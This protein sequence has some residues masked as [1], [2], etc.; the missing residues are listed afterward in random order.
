MGDSGSARSMDEETPFLQGHEEENRDTANIRCRAT[1][2][3]SARG[4]ISAKAVTFSSSLDFVDKEHIYRIFDP[5][6]PKHAG[7][8]NV[9]ADIYVSDEEA[10]GV[11]GDL[12]RSPETGK[13]KIELEVFHSLHCLN[14]LRK[15][16]YSDIYP[17]TLSHNAD[18]HIV[19][20]FNASPLLHR[21]AR[22][23]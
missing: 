12:Y 19:R 13:F 23:S 20:D 17:E 8:R 11:G 1:D 18:I 10:G 2:F 15:R 16:I 5:K 4:A 6:K 21:R 7:S 3:I 9:T 22:K 14:M